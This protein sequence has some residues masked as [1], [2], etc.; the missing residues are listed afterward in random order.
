[1]LEPLFSSSVFHLVVSYNGLHPT[2]HCTLQG[3]RVYSFSNVALPLWLLLPPDR[4]S[5]ADTPCPSTSAA[6]APPTPPASPTPPTSALP[7]P[8]LLLRRWANSRHVTPARTDQVTQVSR[9]L[10]QGRSLPSSSLVLSPHNLLLK[11]TSPTNSLFPSLSPEN[12][13]PLTSGLSLTIFLPSSTFLP[14]CMFSTILCGPLGSSS[15]ET[16]RRVLGAEDVI[17]TSHHASPRPTA[18]PNGYH[19]HSHSHS[20]PHAIPLPLPSQPIPSAS[21]AHSTHHPP[22]A[23][24][25]YFPSPMAPSISATN[26]TRHVGPYPQ[27]CAV[28]MEIETSRTEHVLYAPIGPGFS[29]GK[30]IEFTFPFFCFL[31]RAICPLVR[32]NADMKPAFS[33]FVGSTP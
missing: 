13:I 18:H 17:H 2:H 29:S 14:C 30:L 32:R 6:A 8:S 20:H 19:S 22:R 1:M 27:H 26:S 9:T 11:C 33:G 7:A 23:A 3:H 25:S 24:G 4:P 5:P 28:K 15:S 16:T 21:S 12:H 10:A 31:V